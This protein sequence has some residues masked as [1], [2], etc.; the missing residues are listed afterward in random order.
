ML[1]QDVLQV[2]MPL[3]DTDVLTTIECGL[4]KLLPRCQPDHAATLSQALHY[5]MFPGGKRLRPVLAVLGSRIFGKEDDRVWQAACAVEFVHASSLIIDDLPCMDDASMRR[6]NPALHCV[7]GENIALLAGITLLNQAYAIF[8]QTPELICEATECI[9]VNGMI[10]GQAIDLEPYTDQTSLAERNRKTSALL[11]L[12][13]TAGALAYGVSRAELAPLAAAGQYLGH[14]YQ[15]YDDLR[16]SGP[17][18]QSTGKTAGQDLRHNRPSHAARFDVAACYEE[19]FGLIEK[20]RRSLVD[21]YGSG[22]GVAGLMGF[23]DGMFGARAASLNGSAR[24]KY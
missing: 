20:T 13:A 7:F 4:C 5:A 24:A 10:G 6:G 8:G 1:S 2:S 23:I 11:R 21:A 18:S 15:V 22:A 14:A 3:L 19:L 12:A 16:D 9:G 17:A